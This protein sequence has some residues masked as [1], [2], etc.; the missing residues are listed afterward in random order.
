LFDILP[1]EGIRKEKVHDN[2]VIKGI[3]LDSREVKE[4][5]LFLA[6]EGYVTDGHNYIDAA[7]ANGAVAILCK[8]VPEIIDDHI[9]YIRYS[10]AHTISG[11]I[12]KKFYDDPSSHIKLIGITGTNG[13]SSCVTMAFDLFKSYGYKVGLISTIEVRIGDNRLPS[14]HTTPDPISLNRIL[15]SMVDGK[16]DYVFMEVS[17]HAIH[18]GRIAGIAFSGGVFTNITRDHLDYHGTMLEYLNTKKMFFDGLG[19]EAFALSNIDDKNGKVMLQNTEARKRYYGLHHPCDFKGK[20]LSNTIEGL[21]MDINDRQ[22]HFN[23][24]GRF[25]ASN[26]LAVYGIGI[27]LGMEEEE[28]LV[29]M[30]MLTNAK[31]RFEKVTGNKDRITGIVD[32]AHTPDALEKVLDTLY[33]IRK[34]GHKTI[35]VVGCGGNRDKGKRPLMAKVAV[36]KSDMV[37]LTSDNPRNEDPE[38]IIEEME[39]GIE[40]EYKNKTLRIVDRKEAIRTACRLAEPGDIILVA[41][42]GHESYQE[43]KGEKFPFDDKKILEAELLED[44]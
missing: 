27:E 21:Y 32:Y 3:T 18:Q 31:G 2:P 23:L 26:L 43:I 13:K 14:T 10:D 41:G 6:L 1:E 35:T 40:K 16:C 12:A 39:K 34:P 19:N 36:V 28:L 17:S 22:A 20:I 24:S 38:V 8:T 44:I 15:S 11:M 30:S 29:H 37:I 42:K 4:G 33:E 9:E 7:I 25:N 5:F